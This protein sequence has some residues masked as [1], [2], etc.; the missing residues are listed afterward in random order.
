MDLGQLLVLPEAQGC[1]FSAE[2]SDLR[3]SD[4]RTGALKL[5]IS[6]EEPSTR[7]EV[8]SAQN[9]HPEYDLL[10]E[11]LLRVPRM[12]EQTANPTKT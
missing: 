12:L 4:R 5:E 11:I 1:D 6:R 3:K 2:E 10:I 9:F 7:S 8:G